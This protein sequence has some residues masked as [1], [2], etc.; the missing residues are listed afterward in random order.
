MTFIQRQMAPTLRKALEEKFDDLEMHIETCILQ[1][2]ELSKDDKESAKLTVPYITKLIDGVISQTIKLTRHDTLSHVEE[3]LLD[4]L[5]K[6]NIYAMNKG[7]TH[8]EKN[9]Y[10][11]T[12][13]EYQTFME[14]FLSELKEEN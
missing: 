9:D 5:A 3:R 6:M 10:F 13:E 1:G 7:E 12:I 2:C 14:K 11:L 8:G 4:G